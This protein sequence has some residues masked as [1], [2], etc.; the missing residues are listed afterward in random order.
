[1][2]TRKRA[3]QINVAAMRACGW[4]VDDQPISFDGVTF[5]V[6]DKVRVGKS[7]VFAVGRIGIIRY[8]NH[9]FTP[10]AVVVEFPELPDLIKTCAYNPVH[11]TLIE[12]NNEDK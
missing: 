5:N 10:P 1:M 7:G 2:K 4:N 8:F 12:N 3:K 9:A 11:L 6:E